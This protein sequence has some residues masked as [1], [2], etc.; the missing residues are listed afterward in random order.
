VFFS[1]IFLSEKISVYFMLGGA[2]T[3][4]GVLIMHKVSIEL[5]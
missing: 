5:A 1:I 3:I 2:I 4:I